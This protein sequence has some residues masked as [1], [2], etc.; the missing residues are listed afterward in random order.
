MNS[1]SNT[2]HTSKMLNTAKSKLYD[3]LLVLIHL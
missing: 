1:E 2:E 3:K